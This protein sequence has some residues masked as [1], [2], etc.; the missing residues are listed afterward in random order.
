MHQ[1]VIA[2]H[3]HC[4]HKNLVERGARE[5]EREREREKEWIAL[6]LQLGKHPQHGAMY[7]PACAQVKKKKHLRHVV[8]ARESC[9]SM[10]QGYGQYTEELIPLS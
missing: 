6:K 4:W 10:L 9:F 7:A 5:R 8:A 3:V 2:Q 1:E